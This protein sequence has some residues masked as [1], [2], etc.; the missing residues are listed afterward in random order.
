MVFLGPILI[1]RPF[2]VSKILKSY[3]FASLSKICFPYL[4]FFF[5]NFKNEDL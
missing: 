3:F 1:Y 4:T 2:M 5:K